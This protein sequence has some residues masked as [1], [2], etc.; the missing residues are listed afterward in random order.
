MKVQEI[1]TT[2]GRRW[3]M[4]DNDYHPIEEVNAY[5][6][7]LDS[8]GHAEN[9][10]RSYA[11]ALKLYCEFLSL[12]ELTILQIADDPNERPLDVLADFLVWLQHPNIIDSTKVIFLDSEQCRSAKTINTIVGIV[13]SLYDYMG[14]NHLANPLDAY[15]ERID[16]SGFKPFLYELVK[17]KHVIQ[18][19]LLELKEPKRDLEYVTPELFSRMLE[20][21]HTWRDKAIIAIMYEGGLRLGETLGLRIRDIEVWNNK[22][23]IVARNNNI[24]HCQVKNKAEGSVF[25][26]NRTMEYIAAYF[27]HERHDIECEYAFVNLAG[28][29]IGCPMQVDTVEKLFDRISSEVGCSIHPHMCRH[30]CA[31]ARLEAGWDEASIQRQLRHVHVS[32]TKMYEHF[33]DGLLLEKTREYMEQRQEKMGWKDEMND[34]ESVPGE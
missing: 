16:M 5:L 21:C 20:C 14:R 15:K 10:L 9:T 18:R 12:R 29:N 34:E 19:S 33:R 25:V 8:T 26:G 7:F 3:I 27:A 2:R 28:P 31:T 30:G 6:K 22:I 13:L 23:N 11:Y 17:K 32:T 4:L 1:D 24:N